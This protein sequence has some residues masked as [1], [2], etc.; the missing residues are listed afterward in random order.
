MDLRAA[1]PR[2][3]EGLEDDRPGA[4]AGHEPLA[5]CVEGPAGMGWGVGER[6]PHEG[7][8]ERPTLQRDRVQLLRGGRDHHGVDPA[9]AQEVNRA[10]ERRVAARAG[11]ADHVVG[12]LDGQQFPDLTEHVCVPE[13]H[14]QEGID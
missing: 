6:P 12:A 10:E 3:G 7:V 1:G 13:H 8:H 2:A 9:R 11:I 14:P 4:L 5:P